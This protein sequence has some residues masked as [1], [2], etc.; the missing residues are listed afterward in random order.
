[1]DGSGAMR[2]DVI[3]LFPEFVSQV[4]GHGVVGR[5][6]ERARVRR[7]GEGLCRGPAG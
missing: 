2:I 7:M 4:A 1:M 6:Q 3:S 5:A